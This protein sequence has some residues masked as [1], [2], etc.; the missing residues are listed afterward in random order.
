MHT[1]CAPGGPEVQQDR[2]AA[3]LVECDCAIFVGHGEIGSG[4][5]DFRR[6]PAVA[7][8]ENG[9]DY[10]SDDEASTGHKTIITE[11]VA[12]G[13]GLWMDIPTRIEVSVIVPARNEEAALGP[14]LRSLAEQSLELDTPAPHPL[15]KD[16]KERG[17]HG[18]SHPS[19]YEIIVVDDHSHDRTREIAGS[20]PVTVIDAEPLPE[21]WSGKCN[22]CWTGAKAAKGKWLLFTDADTQHQPDS[23]EQA[24]AEA[25]ETR[26]ALLSYSPHQE[27]HGFA[28][29]ALMPLVF[30]EL[31][32]TYK[33]KQVSDPSSP[34]AAANGQYLLVRR[35]AYDAVGGHATVA[36]AI[37]ED[38]E[39]ARLVKQAG[40]RLQFRM[41]DAVRTR[42]YRTFAQ[43]WEGWT[44][45]LALLFPWPLEL[46]MRRLV[47]FLFILLFFDAALFSMTIH[48]WQGLLINLVILSVPVFLFCRRIRRA[49]FDWLSS[50][51]AVF[52]LPLFS[53]LL[54]NSYISHKKG[55]VKWKGR[56]YGERR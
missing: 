56:V 25:Q 46:A 9:E 10:E 5:A 26:A 32:R 50:T 53:I 34:A 52:G 30:A 20:F 44:K 40:Y 15:P 39:L 17:T 47:E 37:L 22:A 1:R 8:G 23:I 24:L 31:A 29:R 38:V 18:S 6:A 54:V 48:D 43:M 3:K 45:N 21:G 11:P 13:S 28:E 36:T 7:G 33:P 12:L 27:V 14:C 16:G 55:A 42:M 2:F 49:H 51:L 41:S 19:E 35:D 4:F